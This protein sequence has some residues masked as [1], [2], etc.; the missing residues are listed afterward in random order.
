M[1]RNIDGV[2]FENHGDW[3]ICYIRSL[4]SELK[5][6]IRSNLATIC[7]GSHVTDCSDEPLFG[8]EATLSSFLDRYK[9]KSEKTKIGMVGEFL[10]HILI[11]E[12][13][14]EFDVSTAFFNMEE[15]SIRKGF[16]LVLYKPKD[17]SVWITEVKSG[18]L[19]KGKS[20]DETAKVL[21]QRAKADVHER[22]NEQEIMYWLNAV[23]AVR[24]SVSDTKS[25]KKSLV[26]ILNQKGGAAFK[27]LAKSE[28]C[29]V[30]L[31]STLFEPLKTRISKSAPKNYLEVLKN[32]K[33]FKGVLV[34][35]IQKET[36]TRVME[37]LVSEAGSVA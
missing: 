33:A 11:T 16:D 3:A 22:L 24:S 6:L 34:I 21:L 32:L 7:H 31:I 8:Y 20:H 30:V 27:K 35:C 13:F 28:D 29:S 18:N 37:F 17:E 14:D 15:K 26:Q 9:D 25:Y 5:K 4:S 36:Y 1:A 23:N 19:L 12:L 10:A 2:D